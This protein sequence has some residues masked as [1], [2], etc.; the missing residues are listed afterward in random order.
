[1]N[2]SPEM[3][4][5][6]RVE[7][8]AGETNEHVLIGIPLGEYRKIVEAAFASQASE[9][10]E[11]DGWVMVPREPTEEMIA[12]ARF[13]LEEAASFSPEQ[14]VTQ[15]WTS[16]L[17]AAPAIPDA[18]GERDAITRGAFITSTSGGG[19][20]IVTLKYKTLAEMQAA[21]GALV[22]ANKEAKWSTKPPIATITAP[23]ATVD[24]Q[25]ELVERLNGY[26]RAYR[27][28]RKWPEYLPSSEYHEF[29]MR[30]IAV[31]REDYDADPIE[32]TAERASLDSV[33]GPQDQ[34]TGKPEPAGGGV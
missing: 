17:A 8:W 16:L 14:T 9:Q 34:S 1:M 11:V 25:R 18:G 26:K 20:Y 21:H 4:A 2:D 31:M 15:C 27:W 22:G 19:E 30:D 33:G 24:A 28:W 23:V 7:Q 32:P 5:R 10:G 29:V 12:K 13:A 3:R 6:L